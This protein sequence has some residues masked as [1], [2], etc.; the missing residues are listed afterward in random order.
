M[1][2]LMRVPTLLLFLLL[3]SSFSD[4]KRGTG[5]DTAATFIN[6]NKATIASLRQ[7]SA[8]NE[9]TKVTD[10][11]KNRLAAFYAYIDIKTDDQ[12]NKGSIRYKFLELVKSK[13][14]IKDVFI[15]EANTSG[16]K[17]D[18]KT[19]VLYPTATDK[20][21]VEIYRYSLQGWRRDTTIKNYQLS[22][23]KS[24]LSGRVTWAQGFNHDDVTISHFHDGKVKV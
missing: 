4:E 15:V 18:I 6:W 21:D 13:L 19:I 12:L 10:Y 7:Q 17:V 16:E 14:E 20:A 2:K 22:V 3:F 9:Q 5:I 1:G 11:Y 8:S 23:N 24:L